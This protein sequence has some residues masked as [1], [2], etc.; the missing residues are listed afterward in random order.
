MLLIRWKLAHWNNAAG[1]STLLAGGPIYSAAIP[2]L[3]CATLMGRLGKKQNRATHVVRDTAR[4]I[5]PDD[6]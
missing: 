2:Q 5:S 3:S 4:I 1:C 6:I